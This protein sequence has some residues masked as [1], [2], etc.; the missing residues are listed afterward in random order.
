LSYRTSF[1]EWF[2]LV[3]FLAFLGVAT[4]FFKYDLL[5]DHRNEKLIDKFARSNRIVSQLY[6]K[7][8]HDRLLG[9]DNDD[10]ASKTSK[11]SETGKLKKLMTQGDAKMAGNADK[12]SKPLADIFPR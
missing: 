9:N 4:A 5:V 11:K 12:S 8:Y 6:P 10:N 7:M 1:P 3:L 2:T